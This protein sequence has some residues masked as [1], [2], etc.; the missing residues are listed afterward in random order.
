LHKDCKN[1]AERNEQGHGK[2]DKVPD[3]GFPD[4]REIEKREEAIFDGGKNVK[5]EQVVFHSEMHDPQ[6]QDGK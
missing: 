1:N 4:D 3:A 2:P 5:K 6:G